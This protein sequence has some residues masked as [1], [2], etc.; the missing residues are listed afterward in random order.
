VPLSFLHGG[1]WEAH[2]GVDFYTLGDG[3]PK[4]LNADKTERVVGSIGFSVAF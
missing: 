2:G 1:S 4:L 3:L